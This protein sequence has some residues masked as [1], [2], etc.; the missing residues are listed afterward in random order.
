MKRI[1]RIP[2][3][4][5]QLANGTIAYQVR[6]NL[7]RQYLKELL[8]CTNVQF[9]VIDVGLEPVEID[10]KNN[11]KFWRDEVSK[12]LVDS[13]PFYLTDFPD[14]YAYLGSEWAADGMCPIIVLEK[15]H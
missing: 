3:D 12:H 8:H 14:E 10:C 2:L 5:L 6:T 1:T 13:Q 9:V 15:A 7:T 11:F 4:S